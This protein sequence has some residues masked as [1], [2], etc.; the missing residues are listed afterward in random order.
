MRCK[1]SHKFEPCQGEIPIYLDCVNIGKEPRQ[2]TINC[3]ESKL[4]LVS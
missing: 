2:Q 1:S 3:A 4:E